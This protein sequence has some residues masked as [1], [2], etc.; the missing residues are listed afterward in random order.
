[1]V[2]PVQ[3]ALDFLGQPFETDA[4]KGKVESL[5]DQLRA[6]S[7]QQEV[8]LTQLELNVADLTNL[9]AKT[10]F[11]ANLMGRE[12]DMFI[13]PEP[14]GIEKEY[15]AW[16]EAVYD[17][18]EYVALGIGGIGGALYI[19]AKLIPFTLKGIAFISRISKLTTWA[20]SAKWAKAAKLG[21]SS[22][23][24]ALAIVLLESVIK[25]ATAKQ[26][27]DHLKQKQ[28]EL[29]EMIT[30]ADLMLVRI[31]TAIAESRVQRERLLFDLGFGP[32]GPADHEEYPVKI[33]MAMSE[34]LRRAST[35]VEEITVSATVKKS[36]RNLL[37]MG[38]SSDAV[39]DL[40]AP[41]HDGVT[42]QMVQALARRVQ[43]E[44]MLL[45]GMTQDDVAREVGIS[46]FQVAVVARVL[47]ARAD[48]ARGYDDE[49]LSERYGISDAVADLQIDLA[50]SAMAQ[51]WA[52]IASGTGDTAALSRTMLIPPE[53]LEDVM[54]EIP[55]RRELLAGASPEGVQANHP[56][57]PVARIAELHR[58]KLDRVDGLL[59][60]VTARNTTTPLTD[61]QRRMLAVSLRVPVS[62][63]PPNGSNHQ[64]MGPNT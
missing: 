64:A 2:K 26:I 29:E 19:S 57:I 47:R 61:T 12:L 7:E 51:D 59:A 4:L 20:G 5:R 45:N 60:D 48:A 53:A 41:I 58:D 27:N 1:M 56:G 10:D 40:M 62:A 39:F 55:A 33:A 38:Q 46:A 21:K 18:L 44:L 36:L 22:V 49:T 14:E 31:E 52:A 32:F 43:T 42:L 30:Q 11:L 9:K 16:E 25:L 15:D 37:I 34:Y 54:R 8:L 17:P 13:P 28:G 23:Y 24:L 63:I 35:S 50:E 6:K 3:E